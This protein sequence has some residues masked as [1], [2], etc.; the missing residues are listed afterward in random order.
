MNQ[1]QRDNLEMALVMWTAVDPT[2]VNLS[3][4]RCGTHACFGG[5]VAMWEY[6]R[7]LGVQQKSREGYHNGVFQLHNEPYMCGTDTEQPTG[8]AFEV[9]RRL[10]GNHDLFSARGDGD[11]DYRIFGELGERI[12]DHELAL[13]RIDLAL[14]GDLGTLP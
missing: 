1:Q 8:S 11:Q 7:A 13:R 9:A 6:F 2:S 5:H 12:S 14:F 4:W 3:E 10:F